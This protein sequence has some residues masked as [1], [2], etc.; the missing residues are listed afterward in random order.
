MSL[1]KKLWDA[2]FAGRWTN[3]IWLNARLLWTDFT[4]LALI[5]FPLKKHLKWRISF[6]KTIKW[7]CPWGASKC[8]CCVR[9]LLLHACLISVCR[10]GLAAEQKRAQF[11]EGAKSMTSTGSGKSSTVSRSVHNVGV[12]RCKYGTHHRL[13]WAETQRAVTQ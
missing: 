2:S 1:Y 7:K 13:G 8:D 9:V 10:F 6:V 4:S 12:T 3:C 5:Y 11:K